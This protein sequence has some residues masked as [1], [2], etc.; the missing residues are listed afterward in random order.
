MRCR[1]QCWSAAWGS[2][3]SR[4]GEPGVPL[5][6]SWPQHAAFRAVDDATAALAIAAASRLCPSLP[7]GPVH[8]RQLAALV[9]KRFAA[10][11]CSPELLREVQLLVCD[12]VP[13]LWSLAAWLARHGRHVR[14]L[15]LKDE[16]DLD[17]DCGS[18]VSAVA[19]CLA[20]V[21][22]AG[23]LVE[24]EVVMCRPVHTE[25][26]AAAR[27]LQRLSLHGFPLHISPAIAGLTALQSLQLKG[28][29]QFAASARL[30]ASVTRLVLSNDCT[31]QND[32]AP[33]VSR[34]IFSPEP[35]FTMPHL[36]P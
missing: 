7:S 23:Q 14:K 12:D 20:T 28:E 8:C 25:W 1:T 4:S 33:E 29:L 34:L 15:C 35:P 6:P 36:R 13:V 18:M 10:A 5:R 11:A 31:E 9:C 22:A 21:G 17:E 26:L 3:S 24:L 27:S 30:P 2:W 16:E 19:T 32:L